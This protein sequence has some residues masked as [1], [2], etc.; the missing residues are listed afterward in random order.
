MKIT[1]F[2]A[3]VNGLVEKAKSIIRYNLVKNCLQGNTYEAES[4]LLTIEEEK[5]KIIKEIATG[6]SAELKNNLQKL[7]DIIMQEEA[8]KEQI[9]L[10]NKVFALLNEEIE[11]ENKKEKE[12][13]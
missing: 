4:Q 5:T 10:E 1:R 12:S 13:K 2:N 11:V 7:A 3:A 9:T 6:S 8:L